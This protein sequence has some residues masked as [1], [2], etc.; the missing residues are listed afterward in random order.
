M[1]DGTI[2][3]TGGTGALGSAVVAAFLDAGWRAVVTWVDPKELERV[4]ER[5][6][7]DPVQADLF[8]PDAVE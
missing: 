2:L 4:S 3:I 6:G 8:D 1:A 5:D 7:L